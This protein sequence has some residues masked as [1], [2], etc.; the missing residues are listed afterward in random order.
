MD[1]IPDGMEG[2]WPAGQRLYRLLDNMIPGLREADG[3]NDPRASID[4]ERRRRYACSIAGSDEVA[5]SAIDPPVEGS[6][7]IRLLTEL[8]RDNSPYVPESQADIM[9]GLHI[10]L[11]N[12]FYVYASTEMPPVLLSNEVLFAVAEREG[13]LQAEQYEMI[14]Q[15][16]DGGYTY[17]LEPTECES[18]MTA[19]SQAR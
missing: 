17:Q 13:K 7:F 9:D 19:L 12:A 15:L 3:I 14:R 1:N 2:R 8:Y 4:M 18:L 16:Q 11:S 6:P 10:P 5:F